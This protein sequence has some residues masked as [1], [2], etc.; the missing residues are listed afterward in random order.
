MSDH[1]TFKDKDQ[2]YELSVK[3][4]FLQKC[5]KPEDYTAF[6]LNEQFY[7]WKYLHNPDGP[8]IIRFDQKDKD[9]PT[10]PRHEYWINGE[11]YTYF[12]PDKIAVIKARQGFKDSLD[13][14]VS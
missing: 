5:P 11:S 7:M 3:T 13:K 1:Y 2:R 10:Q 4:E 14:I 8:A 9:D 12:H 6:E